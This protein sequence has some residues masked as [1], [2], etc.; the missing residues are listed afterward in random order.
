[1]LWQYWKTGHVGTDYFFK[2]LA[3][4]LAMA[5]KFSKHVK[6]LMGYKLQNTN[7]LFQCWEMAVMWWS[8]VCTHMPCFCRPSHICWIKLALHCTSYILNHPD[9]I[10]SVNVL[11]VAIK[12]FSIATFSLTHIAVFPRWILLPIDMILILKPSN[13]KAFDS[14]VATWEIRDRKVND[15]VRE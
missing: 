3:D 5:M 2:T 11:T 13:H 12:T 1:M 6:H 7:I 8:V 15:Y 9:V 4:Q 14:G 10:L